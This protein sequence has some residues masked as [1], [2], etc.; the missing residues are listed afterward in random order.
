M[1]RH[2]LK[3][4]RRFE[5]KDSGNRICKNCNRANSELNGKRFRVDEEEENLLDKREI[6]GYDS[7]VENFYGE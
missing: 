6:M 1:E 5:S 4:N 2:C 7:G 3:C